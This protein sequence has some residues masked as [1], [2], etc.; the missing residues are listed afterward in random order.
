MP[1][2]CLVEGFLWCAVTGERD[3]MKSWIRF[4]PSRSKK[5]ENKNISEEQQQQQRQETQK[6]RNN[7]DYKRLKKKP[8]VSSACAEL[9]GHSQSL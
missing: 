3:S 1:A 8:R 2:S 7:N 5:R 4:T 9:D 6:Q